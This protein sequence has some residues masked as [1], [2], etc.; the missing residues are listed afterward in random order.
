VPTWNAKVVGSA[1]G[2]R[3]ITLAAIITE[4]GSGVNGNRVKLTS[5]CAR[6][7]GRRSARTRADAACGQS[8]FTLDREPNAARDL[9]TLVGEVTS[10]AGGELRRDSAME[11]HV[12]PAPRGQRALPREPPGSKPAPQGTDSNHNFTCS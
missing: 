12:R 9:A 2:T 7:D 11:T 3:G 5:M 4:I 6:L 1:S 10:C 8:G